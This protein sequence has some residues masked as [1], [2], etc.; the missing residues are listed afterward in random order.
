MQQKGKFCVHFNS[1]LG[2]STNLIGLNNQTIKG[3][4]SIF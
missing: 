1:V 4:R 2:K 3:E